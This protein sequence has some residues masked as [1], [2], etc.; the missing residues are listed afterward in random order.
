MF[1]FIVWRV[2]AETALFHSLPPRGLEQYSGAAWGTRDVCQGPVELLLALG[3][4]AAAAGV[5]RRLF[6][7]Q[8]T[9]GGDWSHWFMLEPYSDI[10]DRSSAGDV[11]VW[12][13]K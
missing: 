2:L 8:Y 12:P 5:L 6:A 1:V 3:H 10:R 7:E 11:I 9:P 13:L 4:D